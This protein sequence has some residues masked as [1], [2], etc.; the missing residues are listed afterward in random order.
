MG[1]VEKLTEL[2][3]RAAGHYTRPLSGRFTEPLTGAEALEVGGPSALFREDGLLPVYP[4]L[5]SIDGVQWSA[6]T[7]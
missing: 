1:V 7:A 6:Q 4:P 5:R 3:W 2:R